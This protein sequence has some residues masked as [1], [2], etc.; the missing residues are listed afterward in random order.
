[1]SKVQYGVHQFSTGNIVYRSD[2]RDDCIRYMDKHPEYWIDGEIYD[3]YPDDPHYVHP[4]MNRYV[5]H[6][7]II[8]GVDIVVEA[9]SEDEALEKA[10]QMFEDDSLKDSL[11]FGD[12]NFEVIDTIQ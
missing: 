4:K 3:I 6:G 8:Y 9:A 12:S 5:V 7:S 2:N 10:E 11:K 1:M